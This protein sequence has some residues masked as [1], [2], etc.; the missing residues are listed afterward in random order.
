MEK[1][2]KFR[3]LLSR[4]SLCNGCSCSEINSSKTKESFLVI[5]VPKTL[6]FLIQINKICTFEVCFMSYLLSVRER[7]TFSKFL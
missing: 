1:S 3:N 4:Y 6:C 5:F 2:E 7:E